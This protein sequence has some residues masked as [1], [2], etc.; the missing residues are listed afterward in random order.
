MSI[1]DD[2][3]E[4]AFMATYG[5]SSA[6]P[7][8]APADDP[9]EL[10]AA[11]ISLRAYIVGLVAVFLLVIGF[12]AIYGRNQQAADA[13][14]TAAE[15]ARYAAG[16]SAQDIASGLAAAS[17]Q[18]AKIATTPQIAKVFASSADC[19]LAFA[20][21]GGFSSG[22]IDI[23]DS[24][25][26]VD[27]TSLDASASVGY[28]GAAWLDAA[29]HRQLLYGP[30][31]DPR[32][33]RKVVIESAPIGGRGAVVV[34]LDLDSLGPGLAAT[35]GGPEHLE[36]LVTTA[37]GSSILTRSIDP[38][39]WVGAPVAGTPFATHGTGAERL[40]VDGVARLYGEATVEANVPGDRWVVYA[41]ASR[42]AVLASTNSLDA[43]ELWVLLAGLITLLAAAVV[44]YRRIA[45]PITQLSSRVRAATVHSD[46]GPIRIA[47][48]PIE[49][50]RLTADFND[51]LATVDRELFAASRLAALVESSEDAIV[52]ATIAG[53]ITS[54]NPGAAKL[55]G[56]SEE[57]AIGSQASIL[58]APDRAD[59]LAGVLATIAR[60]ESV[61]PHESTRLRKDGGVL[62]VSVGISPVRD[63]TGAVVG[64]SAVVRDIT[65]RKREEA[66]RTSLHERLAQSQRLESLGALAGGVAHDFNNLLGAIINFVSFVREEV[67]SAAEREGGEGWVAVLDDVDQIARAAERATRLT[68]QL[69]AF[70]RRDAIR[71]EVLSLNDVA[72]GIER[73]LQRTLGEDVEVAMALDPRLALAI[74]DPGQFEQVIVNL[75]VNARDAMPHGGKLSI[76]TSNVEVDATYA[77]GRPNLQAGSY[78]QFRVSDI[79]GGM[80]EDVAEHAFEPFY[81]TKPK[82]E[83][84]GL[85]L[86]TVYGI[87]SQAGGYVAI[88]SERY[89]GTTITVLLPAS[90]DAPTRHEHHDEVR[91]AGAGRSVL[92]VEDEDA[93]REATRRILVGAGYRVVTA[94]GGAEALE[95]VRGLGEGPDILVTDVVMPMMLGKELVER[96]LAA[97]PDTAVLYMS[98]YAESVLDTRGRLE[99]GVA[100]VTKPF[101]RAMLLDKVAEVLRVRLEADGAQ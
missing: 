25:G 60:G 18:V 14:R 13:E 50:A 38:R 80:S 91:H 22:H 78:V 95:A 58:V 7:G 8:T 67:S 42:E 2:D 81:T 4:S 23:I 47:A 1:R 64:L 100:L 71:P 21:A 30:V 84:T 20:G 15:G 52:G 31:T 36:F 35:F 37:D 53:T 69:L 72:R 93:L 54:W 33:G 27:C 6:L 73:L 45:R 96:V 44:L 83:G 86:A 29:V 59:A 16:L 68:R 82:G 90:R 3:G 97:R 87:V 88:Y 51:L 26:R 61:E 70:A 10:K 11:R 63:R 55:F 24:S 39:R 12:A 9:P 34:F 49:V 28:S 40:D 66:E 57:E 75:A 46:P 74:I 65:H 77:I 94:C 5:K 62:D 48:A 17:D 41:G 85:G 92:V 19:S 32:T 76:Q 56:Y 99:A 98:G 43:R 79:G 101:S 89:L